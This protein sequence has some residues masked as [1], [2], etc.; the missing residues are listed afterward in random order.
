MALSGELLTI[1]LGTVFSIVTG[2]AKET[3]DN[4]HLTSVPFL[5]V[6]RRFK[7]S[8]RIVQLQEARIQDGEK[9]SAGHCDNEEC[10]ALTSLFSRNGAKEM[11]KTDAADHS[12]CITQ[13]V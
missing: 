12:E 3:K 2:G 11:P 8:R 7:F 5:N 4:L 1:I 13:V 6:L 10:M 9:L